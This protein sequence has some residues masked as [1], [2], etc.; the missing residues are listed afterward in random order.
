MYESYSH[1]ERVYHDTLSSSEQ[2]NVAVVEKRY[3]D[4]HAYDIPLRFQ[5]MASGM[6]VGAKCIVLDK[7]DQMAELDPTSVDY[8]KMSSKLACLLSVPFG[9]YVTINKNLM[10]LENVREKLDQDVY[11]HNEAKGH[12][13]RALAQWMTSPTSKGVCIGIRG[14]PGG[15]KTLLCK[16]IAK[17]IGVPMEF[18]SLGSASGEGSSYLVGHG[19]T[20]IGSRHGRIV[21]CLIRANCMNPVICMDELDKVSES[22]RGAEIINTLIHLTDSAQNDHFADVYF[23]ETTFD[24]SRCVMLFS[25]NQS[26][27]IDPIL[28][29]RM[30]MIDAPEYDASAKLC[31]A[32][33]YMIPQILKAYSFRFDDILFSDKILTH[34]QSV[35]TS[36]GGV[37]AFR[38]A[39]DDI[40]SHLNLERMYDPLVAK[41]IIVT[42]TMVKKFVYVARTSNTH[43]SMFI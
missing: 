23:T 8:F 31:I 24:M 27:R 15:G 38:R 21:D 30:V 32:K 4:L 11:G 13:I 18:I 26:D 9:K 34:L 17:A 42:K 39:L 12:I 20:Y 7:L 6:D 25:F 36:E 14:G 35:V 5:I 43:M 1:D 22:A 16:S 28:L 41:P 2:D 37:R 40:V 10:F 19:H 33:Q 3:E 29:D